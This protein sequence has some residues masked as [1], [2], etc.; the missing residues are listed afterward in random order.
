MIE[1]GGLAVVL[2]LF[3]WLHNLAGT[4]VA[5]ATGNAR[6]A[7]A[8]ERALGIDIEL[9]AN[10]FLAGHP[11]LVTSAVLYYRLYYV[12]LAAVLLWLLFRRLGAY[13]EVRRTIL[14]MAPLALLIFWLVPM[15]PPR[16]ALP[17]IID[18]VAQ[19]DLF[20]STASVDLANGQNHFSAMP[21]MHVG[22][23]A[24]CAYAAWLALHTRYPRGALLVWLFPAGMVA[25]VLATGNHYVLDVA[26]SA[27]L[28]AV[29][30]AAARAWQRARGRW[31]QTPRRQ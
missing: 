7:Q 25:V 6:G 29:S 19:H 24:L 14:V 11:A 4:D 27:V 13:R 20:G 21:S 1:L 30:I 2:V 26:G 3:S 31:S 5:R 8:A 16:F 18:L 28:L 10:H 22:W 23:S 12:P 17:G 9:A 15:S